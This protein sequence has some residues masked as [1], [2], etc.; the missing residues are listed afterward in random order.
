MYIYRYMYRKRDYIYI[1][2]IYVYRKRDLHIYMDMN[3]IWIIHALIIRHEKYVHIYHTAWETHIYIGIYI[4]KETIYIHR[5]YIYR[6][7][8]P[9]MHI[10]HDVGVCVC[11]ICMFSLTSIDLHEYRDSDLYIFIQSDLYIYG[12]RSLYM[13][14][15]R[16]LYMYGTRPFD[17]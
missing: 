3:T 11:I 12:K 2:P 14:M 1:H 5:N 8:D 15:K 6:K 7:R 17:I 10:L 16:D 13:C 4:G 9:Y